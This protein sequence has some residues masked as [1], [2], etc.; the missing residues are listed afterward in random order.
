MNK[1]EKR[2]LMAQINLQLLDHKKQIILF[3]RLFFSLLFPEK[4][5]HLAPNLTK[6]EV[7]LSEALTAII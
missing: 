7:V 3:R 6:P 2:A 1:E 4:Y 5:Q